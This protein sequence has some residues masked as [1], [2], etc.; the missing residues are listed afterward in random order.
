[1]I[2][3]DIETYDPN[4]NGSA[5]GNGKILVVGVYDGTHYKCC[6]PDE[7]WLRDWLA[8]KEDKVFHNGIYDL[9]WLI[10]A[11]GFDVGGTWH[12]TMTRTALIDEYADL[13]LDSCCKKF[14]VPGKNANETIE[15]WWEENKKYLGY[16]GGF[17]G[18]VNELWEYREIQEQM[19]KYNRQDCIATYNL[20]MAQEPYLQDPSDRY[21]YDVECR[22]YPVILEMRKNGVRID[23]VARDRLTSQIYDKKQEVI[24]HLKNS[25]SIDEEVIASPKK[26]GVAMN[27]L[28]VQSPVVTAKGNQSWAADVLEMID[29]PAIE[30][31][32]QEKILSSLLTKYLAGALQTE[33]FNGR[34]YST[35][36][37]NKRDNGGTI[38]GRLASRQPNLQNIPA[39][40]G[41]HGQ[42]SYG[43]EMRSLFLPEEGM[44]FGA[45][46]YSAIEYL[47]LA[48]FAHGPQADWLREQANSGVDFHVAAMEMTGITSR[49]VIKRMNYG[50]IYGMGINKLITINRSLFKKLAAEAGEDYM[51]YGMSLYN[52]YHQQLPVIKDT[53]KRI[54]LIVQ[55]QGY[56]RSIGG[57]AHHKPKPIFDNGKWNTGMY[58][59]TNYEIQGTA[60]DILKKALVNA[61]EDGIF[62]TMPLH[63]TVHDEID[64]SVPYNKA[65]TEAMKELK[66]IMESTYKSRLNV[67]MR[68]NI[69]VGANWGAWSDKIWK[70]MLEGKYDTVSV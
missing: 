50:F 36:S 27:L 13:D 61:Y 14:N 25:Y 33:V 43:Q 19:I 37:P 62:D 39:R 22:L 35:F 20:F 26:L 65:G 16:K 63:L 31:I 10:C 38:T 51:A 8:S 32:Q 34:I 24:L 9:P 59:M 1:M 11:Y 54:E 42:L 56:I 70:E 64:V 5:S 69:E 52:K 23:T 2:A 41:K 12:D 46:D 53:M 66:H 49:D 48:H 17:W 47:L 4:M 7:P 29:H 18:N 30:L 28:G 44:M 40:E 57:R 3:V 6:E 58:R 67:P 68:A 21:A 55:Q 60:S 15:K 45:A